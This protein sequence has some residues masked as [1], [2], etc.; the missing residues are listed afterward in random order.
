M[1]SNNDGNNFSL[2]WYTT[3]RIIKENIINPGSRKESNIL[4]SDIDCAS[5]SAHKINGVKGSGL[6][7]KKKN[8][9]IHTLFTGVSQ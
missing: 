1:V 4:P 6:F 2:Y 7:V 8:V 3:P 5:F 9:Q